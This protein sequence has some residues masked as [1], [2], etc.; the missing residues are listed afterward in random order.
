MCCV[1]GLV[2]EGYIRRKLSA[3][4]PLEKSVDHEGFSCLV[5][6]AESSLRGII[7]DGFGANSCWLAFCYCYLVQ[8]HYKGRVNYHRRVK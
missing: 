2:I 1:G 7:E 6:D 8:L 5:S 3:R 4:V